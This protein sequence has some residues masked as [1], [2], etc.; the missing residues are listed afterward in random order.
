M[1]KTEYFVLIDKW[2]KEGLT[3]QEMSNRYIQLNNFQK[4]IRKKKEVEKFFKLN[5][6]DDNNFKLKFK[7]LT[8]SFI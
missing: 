3:Y 7:E 5:N 1:N 8:E 2:K 4:D 6:P